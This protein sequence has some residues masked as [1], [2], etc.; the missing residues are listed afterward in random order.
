MSRARS[1]CGFGAAGGLGM[2]GSDLTRQTGSA[3]DRGCVIRSTAV[4]RVPVVG[5]EA[6][7]ASPEVEGVQCR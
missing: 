3:A 2:A 7:S 5:S 1:S 4:S 6:T